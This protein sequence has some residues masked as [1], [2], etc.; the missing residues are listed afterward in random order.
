[1]GRLKADIVIKN[2]SLIDVNT[3]EIRE[4]TDIA[5]KGDRIAY[6][7][8]ASHTIGDGTRVIDVDGAYAAPGFMDAHIHVESSH[9]TPYS[10][11]WT[12]IKFGTTTVF[13][14]PHEIANVL[15]DKGIK[16]MIR[17]SYRTPIK[18][19]ITYPSCVPAARDIDTSGAIL[20]VKDIAHGLKYR[21]VI[22]LGE[23]MNFPG[24]ISGDIDVIERIKN[25]LKMGYIAEGHIVG[26]DEKKLTSYFVS[27]ITS[28][29]ESVTGKEA[30][31]KLR[32][33]IHLYVRESSFSK[34]L[35]T[36]IRYLLS[37]RV[38]TRHIIL[39]SDD[40]SAEDL[41][42][43]GHV[44]H[45]IRLAIDSGMDPVAA[46]Q[47]VTLNVAEHYKLSIEL[48]SIAP[49]RFG[50]IVIFE[51][52]EK[53]N[54]K[55]VLC[56]GRII[57]Y[58]GSIID[59][60]RR[61]PRYPSWALKTVKIPSELSSDGLKFTV[62]GAS[63]VILHVMK[64][65]G[66]FTRDISVELEVIKGE[67]HADPDK[68][69]AKISVIE[70]HGKGGGWSNGFIMGL[71]LEFGA[72]ASTVAHD[73]HNLIV[74]GV[75]IDDMWL[76]IKEI[77]RIQGGFTVVGNGRV[78]ASLKLNIAG[79]MSPLPCEKV[80]KKLGILMDAYR[81]IGRHEINPFLKLLFV[82]LPVIPELKL[83][84]KGYVDVL[85]GELIDPIISKE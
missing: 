31:S 68:D 20:G 56:D 49:P 53:I 35:K 37:K 77:T 9:L 3:G 50:D 64:P 81:K 38:D 5:I 46:I 23:M 33:G 52:L 79:L 30:L 62:D 84:N 2:C 69:I 51:D 34:N 7:G 83:T 66:L 40:V 71:G 57:V 58:N 26:V 61:R 19:L 11:G 39:V 13:I 63:K 41:L 85:K 8:D 17:D 18:I 1:M 55:H 74:A 4:K 60:P 82:S 70:R 72:L 10:F 75:S 27:G 54:V 65:E 42:H 48:G 43:R 59:V 14:D 80:A 15:G 24:V 6:V 78:L 36:I 12:V 16:L 73:S 32:L 67:V 22:A 44:D 28:D 45:L 76:A 21:E 25:T 47:A 29:H